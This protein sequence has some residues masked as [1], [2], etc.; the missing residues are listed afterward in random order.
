MLA[1]ENGFIMTRYYEL[2]NLDLDKEDYDIVS[3]DT[4]GG[5]YRSF[6]SVTILIYI[7]SIVRFKKS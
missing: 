3:I 1:Y 4:I 2:V 5:F 6:L 7:M